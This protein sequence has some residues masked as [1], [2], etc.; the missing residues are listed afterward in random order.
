MLTLA[1]RAPLGLVKKYWGSRREPKEIEEMIDEYAT[2]GKLVHQIPAEIDIV[3]RVAD[4]YESEK[5]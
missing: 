2:Q 1:C 3:H 4:I 5:E